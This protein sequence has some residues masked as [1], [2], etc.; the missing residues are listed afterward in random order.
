MTMGANLFH[1]LPCVE[2]LEQTVLATKGTKA[3]KSPEVAEP[4]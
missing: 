3:Q 2:K 1:D 4:I